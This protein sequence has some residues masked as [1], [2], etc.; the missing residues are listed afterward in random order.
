MDEVIIWKVIVFESDRGEKF[1]EE[2]LK[3]LNKSTIS[4]VSN[5]IQLLQES[6]SLLGMPHS[7]KL[8][9]DIY[10][11]RIRG[12]EEIRIFYAFLGR[13]IYLLHGFKKKTQ[14]TPQKEIDIAIRRFSIL[15]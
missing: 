8:T 12:R 4:K 2:F 7:K 10:E 11:L 9:K 13:E 6:G 1:V 3:S 5:N 15:K 14:K